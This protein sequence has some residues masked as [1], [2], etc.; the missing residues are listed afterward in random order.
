[1]FEITKGNTQGQTE[2]LKICIKVIIFK[3]NT[4]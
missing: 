4:N 1:M 2:K 3:E